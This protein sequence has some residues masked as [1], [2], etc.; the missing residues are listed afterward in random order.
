MEYVM[1][2]NA[3][4]GSTAENGVLCWSAPKVTVGSNKGFVGGGVLCWI[5]LKAT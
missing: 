2:R 1:P 5:I 4:N 3:T